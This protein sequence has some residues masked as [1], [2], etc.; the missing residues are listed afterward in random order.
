MRVRYA[1]AVVVA[2]AVLLSTGC[3]LLGSRN[4][5]PQSQPQ[6]LRLYVGE[7]MRDVLAT[8]TLATF[9]PDKERDDTPII[10]PDDDSKPSSF[11]MT[12]DDG[13]GLVQLP[14]SRMVWATQYAGVV[15]DIL[16]S[17]SQQKLTLRDLYQEFHGAAEQLQASGWKAQVPVPSYATLESVVQGSSAVG[18]QGGITT[19]TKGS[20]KASLEIKG[21]SRQP[22]TASA[23]SPDYTLNVRFSDE[24][25]NDAQQTKVFDERRKILGNADKNL[26][27]A[28]WLT[29]TAR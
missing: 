2:A 23:Q 3:N 16:V 1:T 14:H 11:D 26:N 22:G 8:N 10:W 9:H 5:M 20:V 18:L 19:F 7:P 4:A 17:A 29:L 12:Y 21:F 15:T 13:G 28:H 24:R 6:K 25:L 27:L